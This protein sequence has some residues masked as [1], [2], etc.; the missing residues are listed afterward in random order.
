MVVEYVFKASEYIVLSLREELVSR[1]F[2]KNGCDTNKSCI[3]KKTVYKRATE[4]KGSE[5]ARSKTN[6]YENI[7]T[8]TIAD[9][10]TI[11]EVHYQLAEEQEP[12][13]ERPDHHVVHENL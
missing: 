12:Q 10:M 2:M 3:S 11:N 9:K 13:M 1:E 5:A 8:Y 6:N 4:T 7:F